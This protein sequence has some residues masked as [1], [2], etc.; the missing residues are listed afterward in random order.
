MPHLQKQLPGN[1]TI[2][3]ENIPGHITAANV[4]ER[5]GKPDG[6][7]GLVTSTSLLFAYGLKPEADEVKFDPTKWNTVL[8]SPLGNVIYVR[9][10][11]G[12]KKAEELATVPADKLVLGMANA[13]GSDIRTL[14]ALEMLGTKAKPVIGLDGG[15]NDMA[16]MR[17]ETNVARETP[18]NYKN[19][20]LALEEKGEILP[21][22][23]YGFPDASGNVG[24]DP[25]W[26]DLPTFVEVYKNIHG[27]DPSGP[28]YEAYKAFFHM[29]IMNQ[30]A[31][32]LPAGTPQEIVDAFATAS[33]K[34]IEDPDFV[35]ETAA[36]FDGYPLIAG[37]AAQE[38]FSSVIAFKPET[39]AW[40]LE[41][42]KTRFPSN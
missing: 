30:K 9:T 10:S 22:F 20:F 7:T 2:V 32:Q 38:S 40:I 26:K 19:K 37:K 12:V 29:G 31:L 6:L 28:E 21:L 41:W 34:M 23:T 15:Q 36:V 4:F 24:R 5:D 16:M 35:K 3:V 27:K 42:L 11:V 18:T 39:R 8:I 33:Q 14:L 13:T 1:P 25:G 17:G